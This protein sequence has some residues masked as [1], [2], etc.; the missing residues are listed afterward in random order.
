[1]RV[2]IV[3]AH[4]ER[5]SFNGQMADLAATTLSE[6]GHDVRLLDLYGEDFDAREAAWHYHAAGSQVCFDVQA[7]QRRASMDGA[8]PAQAAAALDMVEWADLI[9]LQFP[10]W[11]F[12]PPAI[13]KGWI[14]R[15]LVYG[16]TYSSQMRYDRG[17][18]KGRRA[19]L[20]VT[21]GG[22]EPTFAHN[23]RNGDIDL[24]LWPTQM[25][26]HYVGLTVLPPH[27]AFDVHGDRSDPS[28]TR[29]LSA[30]MEAFS[31]RLVALDNLQPL[32]F[33]GW[34]DWDDTGRLRPGVE[35]HNLFI[36]QRP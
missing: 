34:A 7:E 1:M 16:R 12:A 31:N 21:A 25:S 33:H 29:S 9:I 5:R 10:I 8:L 15:V 22:S 26:L 4:P 23:G 17:R 3:L 24:V 2:L 13:L 28:T 30:H 32:A 11:W 20:S 6:F 36:R 18:L 19:M 35:G 14:D 27:V